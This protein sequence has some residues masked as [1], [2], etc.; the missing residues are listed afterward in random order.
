MAS[1]IA[2]IVFPLYYLA[3]VLTMTAATILT[4]QQ[5]SETERYRR[6]F[7]L[8]HKLGMGEADM[9]NALR[10]QFVIYYAMPILPSLLISGP[11]ILNLASITDPG[12][13]Y[14]AG[15]PFMVLVVTFA[16]FFLIY[17]IYIFMAYTSMK[18]NVLP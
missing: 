3:L 8:L 4:I 10:K 2:T 9:H 7:A 12:S 6:Q 1:S 13:L 14:G 15:G 11:F 16:L 5:L 18:R 17:G